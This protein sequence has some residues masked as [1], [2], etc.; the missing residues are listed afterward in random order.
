MKKI[1]LIVQTGSIPVEA[2]EDI[3][4]A[5]TARDKYNR[6]EEILRKGDVFKEYNEY[7]IEEICLRR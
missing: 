6:I 3:E 5:K 7:W 2:Y 1:Y 4:I